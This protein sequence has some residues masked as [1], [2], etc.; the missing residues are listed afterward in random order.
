[1]GGGGNSGNFFNPKN[2]IPTVLTGGLY[3]GAKELKSSMTPPTPPTPPPPPNP[4]PAAYPH[5]LDQ[6]GAETAV[7]RQKKLAAMQF[8]F[9]STMTNKSNSPA[10]SLAT[11]TATGL[12]TKT[13]Q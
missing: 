9:A 8:G 1:M 5:A 12:K 6:N 7:Q 10:A 3:Y 13:G 2:L 4:D 11:A